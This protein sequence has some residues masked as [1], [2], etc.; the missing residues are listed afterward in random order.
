MCIPFATMKPLQ[1]YI[2]RSG[3]QTGPYSLEE[4]RSHLASGALV[5]NDLAWHE[6]A[7][8][9]VTLGS[10][11]GVALPP[12]IVPLRPPSSGCCELCRRPAPTI[13]VSLNRH[14]GALILMFHKSLSGSFCKSCISTA[15]RDYTLTTLFLGWWGLISFFV[16]P[17]V[18][19]NNL[20]VYVRSR[21]MKPS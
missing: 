15:F 10:V 21:F 13:R 6:G 8:D 14:I 11:P 7:S 9:W 4:I 1:I 2:S 18:L 12:K 5:P 20:L 17:I 3:Q 19:I 16:T